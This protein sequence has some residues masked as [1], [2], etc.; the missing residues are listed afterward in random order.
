MST[1]HDFLVKTQGI[2]RNITVQ[3]VKHAIIDIQ[4]KAPGDRLD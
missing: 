2:Q 1:I 3:T 4:V